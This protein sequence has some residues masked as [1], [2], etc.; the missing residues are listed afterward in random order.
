MVQT[1]IP[2]FESL[3]VGDRAPDFQF[4][5]VTLNMIL[6]YAGASGDF[7]PLH[8]DP[9]FAKAAGYPSIFAMGMMSAAWLS[10]LLTDWVGPQNVRRYKVRFVNQVWPGDVLTC[11]GEVTGKRET[12]EGNLVDLDLTVTNQKGEV[13]LKGSAAAALP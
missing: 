2:R 11:S 8:N 13:V 6:R 12:A 4:G 7:N 10:R 3:K 5:P 1:A 9:D